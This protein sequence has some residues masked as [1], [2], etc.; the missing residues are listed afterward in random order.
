MLHIVYRRGR[1]DRR[2]PI[3]LTPPSAA[4]ARLQN[5]VVGNAAGDRAHDVQ[6][7]ERRHARPSPT[8]IEPWIREPETLGGSADGEAQ[9]ETLRFRAILLQDE[10]G[11]ERLAHLA[12]EQHRIFARLLRKQPL[13]QTGNED[14]AKR[15]AARLMWAPDEDLSISADGRMFVESAQAVRSTRRA[16]PRA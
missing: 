10:S 5:L 13:G 2:W 11:I 7:I 12:I 4:A 16:L 9:Q 14:H 8:D 6:H 1:S 3:E 15:T